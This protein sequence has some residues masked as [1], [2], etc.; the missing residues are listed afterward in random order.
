[1]NESYEQELRLEINFLSGEICYLQKSIEA[2]R[3]SG[4]TDAG[5]PARTE[6]VSETLRGTGKADGNGNRR[7][8]GIQRSVTA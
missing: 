3:N 8:G 1:M 5:M 7:T 4:D 6:T 2:A